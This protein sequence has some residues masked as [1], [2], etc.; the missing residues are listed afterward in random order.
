MT[1]LLNFNLS[2]LFSRFSKL[3]LRWL[4][5]VNL[6]II[7][8][9]IPSYFLGVVENSYL[10]TSL[11]APLL[12]QFILILESSKISPPFFTVTTVSSEKIVNYAR[13]PLSALFSLLKGSIPGLFTSVSQH[14]S[15]QNRSQ[16]TFAEWTPYK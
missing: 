16:W 14:M 1:Q 3:S 8:K 12:V 9:K 11:Q 15:T 6:A 2:D 4:S 13:G 7:R 5:L 10:R